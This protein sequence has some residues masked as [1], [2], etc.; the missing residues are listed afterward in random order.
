MGDRGNIGIEHPDGNFIWLYGHWAGAVMPGILQSTLRSG[1]RRIDDP[2]FLTRIIFQAL[3]GDDKSDR[4]YGIGTQP[5]GDG[6]HPRLVLRWDKRAR[7]YNQVER[8]NH[9]VDF[10]PAMA[11]HLLGWWDLD[12]FLDL[13]L[14]PEH[15]DSS[16]V[17]AELWSLKRDHIKSVSAMESSRCEA[18][19]GAIPRHGERPR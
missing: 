3:V 6:D 19:A 15:R 4:F 16:A 7:R 14:G 17:L 9:C 10:D 1:A 11:Q 12:E 18:N 5:C 13:D 2:D 8:W